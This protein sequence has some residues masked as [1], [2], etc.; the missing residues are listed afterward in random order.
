MI[1]RIVNDSY[2]NQFLDT[3]AEFVI[4]NIDIVFV[5]I[6]GLITPQDKLTELVSKI[7]NK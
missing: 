6:L 5:F 2:L 1:L 7:K 4:N 3:S